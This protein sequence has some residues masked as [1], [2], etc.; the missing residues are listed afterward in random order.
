MRVA[1][2][3]KVW[4]ASGAAIVTLGALFACSSFSS[5]GVTPPTDNPD[6]SSDAG[7]DT[8]APPAGPDAGDASAD[9]SVPD[10]GFAGCA[11]GTRELLQNMTSY[12]KV[13]GCAGGFD[14][15]GIATTSPGCGHAAGNSSN[16]TVTGCNAGDLC[17][18]GWHVCAGANEF[19]TRGGDCPSMDGAT[20]AFYATAQRSNGVTKCEEVGSDDIFGCGNF[21]SSA[22]TGCNPLNHSL[23]VDSN[24]TEAYPW[25]FGINQ[26]ERD[27]VTKL[28]ADKGGVLCCT[29]AP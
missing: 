22:G 14:V 18:A 3:R 17:A 24:A 1:S 4:L 28:T 10:P 29:D 12:P 11:D 19:G 8:T 7:S 9:G 15:A 25:K 13:A 27:E 23:S 5:D 21:G 16:S 20:P 26:H 2:L 6:A